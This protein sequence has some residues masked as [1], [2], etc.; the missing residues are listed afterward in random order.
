MY[1]Q[2]KINLVIIIEILEDIYNKKSRYE[3]SLKFHNTVID[4]SISA[5]IKLRDIYK[6]NKVALSGGVFQNEILLNG[7]IN[8]LKG[9]GFD[10][11]THRIIPCN[12]SGIS[13]GQLL[14][15]NE[16]I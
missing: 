13:Y 14:I 16:K 10:V 3:I 15:G 11:L 4:F 9:Y 1:N 2:V 8:G 6:I 5:A 12:D 7:I